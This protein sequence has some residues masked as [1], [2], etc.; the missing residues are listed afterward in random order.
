MLALDI[1]F[2]GTCSA[3]P[4]CLLG[5]SIQVQLVY[6]SRSYPVSRSHPRT[7]EL[8]IPSYQLQNVW[9]LVVAS[10]HDLSF[11]EKTRSLV[12]WGPRNGQKWLFAE[13]IKSQSLEVWVRVSTLNAFEAPHG[14]RKT[15]MGEGEWW[16]MV[17][18]WGP[19]ACP[20]SLPHPDEECWVVQKFC[21]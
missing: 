18:V 16:A 5:P 12:H 4:C 13:T 11:W 2:E 8:A 1:V 6:V 3:S 20:S 17:G 15:E 19:E 14:V 21:I 9:R 7:L 10:S